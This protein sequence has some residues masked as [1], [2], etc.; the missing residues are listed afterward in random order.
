MTVRSM[1]RVSG[2]HDCGPFCTASTGQRQ[3]AVG[4]HDEEVTP[5]LRRGSRPA[6]ALCLARWPEHAA[7]NR[8]IGML[9]G[10]SMWSN[11]MEEFSQ[12][13]VLSNGSA[14]D[15]ET[16]DPS[17]V[18]LGEGAREMLMFRRVTGAAVAR[19]LS[20]ALQPI[21]KFERDLR[22]FSVRMLSPFVHGLHAPADALLAAIT[23]DGRRAASAA[24]TAFSP[25]EMGERVNVAMCHEAIP[26]GM[27]WLRTCELRCLLSQMSC[28]AA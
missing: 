16:P 9:H 20:I 2:R 14:V 15:E 17:N 7:R 27:W 5:L 21:Q 23:P 22:R 10:V 12:A 1:R 24:H 25:N 11:D 6:D 19:H 26:H 18:W 8:K 4:C 13:D 3:M 28:H